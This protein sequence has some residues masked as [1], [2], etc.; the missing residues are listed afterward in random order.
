MTLRNEHD[1]TILGGGLAGLTLARQ[2]SLARPGTRILIVEAS[3]HPPPDAAHKVGESCVEIGGGWLHDTLQLADHLNTSQLP[4]L[5]LRFFLPGTG[6]TDLAQRVEMG[7]IRK[8]IPVPFSGL[9]LPSYQLDRGRLETFLAQDM[10]PDVQFVDRCKATGVD[11][12]TETDA[13]HQVHLDHDGVAVTVQ[14][15]WVIDG[16]GR[17]ALLRKQL[18]L[19]RP[20]RHKA[21][22]V[23]F[24]FPGRIKPDTWSSDPEWCGRMAEPIRWQ[25]TTHLMDWGYWAWL[26]PLPSDH[27]SV[28]IVIDDKCH[29]LSDISTFE[30]AMAWLAI[31]EPQ[32][33]EKIAEAMGGEP[34]LDFHTRKQ[35]PSEVSQTF[36]ADRWGLTGDAGC[37]VDPFYSPGTDFIGITNSFHS[38]LICRDLDGEDIRDRAVRSEHYYGIVYEQFLRV[39]HDAYPLMGNPQVMAAKMAF[40]SAFYWGWATLLFRNG[41]LTD[42]DFMDTIKPEVQRM[43]DVQAAM[44]QTLRQWA[45][46]ECPPVQAG[47]VDQFELNTLW[48]LYV[49]LIRSVS[50][51]T[52]RYRVRKNLDVIEAMSEVI[53]RRAARD[54]PQVRDAERLNARAF[55][56]EPDRWE[57]DGLFQGEDRSEEVQRVREETQALWIDG[58]GG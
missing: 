22:A 51:D 27:M 53:F 34:P 52:L 25:S 26:I 50:A 40:D 28:G 8:R 46:R 5:G 38:D 19:G 20:S 56:L 21:S 35:Y 37:F 45:E 33:A 14:T 44:Q 3:E 13:P 18:G 11:L 10:P 41:G 43:I 42:P 23:W 2:V 55:S 29:D 1:L 47:M 49:S 39:Y 4:K 7:P 30:K 12:A 6:K 48:R 36:S 32:A 17:R 16:T 58:T 57:A 9:L 31:H 54:F 24:R 15:R